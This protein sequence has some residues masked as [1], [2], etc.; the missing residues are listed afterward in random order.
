[1]SKRKTSDDKDVDEKRPKRGS[2]PQIPSSSSV[3]IGS[4]HGSLSNY[5]KALL[6]ILLSC[7]SLESKEF[8]AYLEKIKPDFSMIIPNPEPALSETLKKINNS[9]RKLSLEI[10]SMRSKNDEGEWITTFGL[11][12]T[13]ADFVMKDHG[14]REQFEDSE[15][16]FFSIK[17]LP[18][19]VTSKYLTTDEVEELMPI[20]MT[21]SKMN[22]LL[23]RLALTKWLSRSDDK[24]FWELGP[25]S[26]IEL[27][28]NL[29]S[30]MKDSLDENL[31]DTERNAQLTELKASL[32][33]ILYY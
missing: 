19:L 3:S 6:Q 7:G 27:R 15:L 14:M 33:Q 13:E 8:E 30:I 22:S 5:E 4:A 26:F 31:D 18:K 12:N 28:S 25:R 32:P 17:L 10:R 24:G 21:K 2:T 11:V 23:K 9:I 29:E 16:R 20:G 1:M